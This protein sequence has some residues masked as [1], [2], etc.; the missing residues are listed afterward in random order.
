MSVVASAEQDGPRRSWRGIPSG[1]RAAARRALLIDAAFDLLGTAGWS[2]VTLRG[3]CRRARLHPRYFYQSFADL[4]DLL[5]AVF[6]RLIEEMQEAISAELDHAGGAAAA[7]SRAALHAVA[8]FVADDQ[9]RA[10]VFYTEA[11]GNDRLNKRRI[12]TMQQFVGSLVPAGE[13]A[14]AEVAAHI[15]V[16]GFT[17]A[18]VAWLDG[19]LD[20]TIDEL[21]D[22]ASTIILAAGRAAGRIAGRQ[23]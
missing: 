6:D 5:L 15:A 16:G 21:V 9:R 20:V 3:V 10:R 19:R 14:A 1:E 13:D 7:R 4:D 18:L 17:S 8:R 22:D 11:L 12:E 2:A 23:S